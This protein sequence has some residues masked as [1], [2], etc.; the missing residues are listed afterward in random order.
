MYLLIIRH[1]VTR[2]TFISGRWPASPTAPFSLCLCFNGHFPGGP[3]LASAKM[4]P[5]WISLELRMMEV[6]VTT[7]AIRRAKLQSNHHHQQTNTQ[8][9]TGR[10]PPVAQPST[11]VVIYLGLNTATPTQIGLNSCLTIDYEYDHLTTTSG[12]WTCGFLSVSL[13]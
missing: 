8:F 11:D 9:F 1:K 2:Q 13:F 4:S 5:F 6:V 3:G 10:M 12:K 7:G